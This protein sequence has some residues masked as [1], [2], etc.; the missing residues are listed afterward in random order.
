MTNAKQNRNGFS[1]LEIIA[2][3]VISAALAAFGI[4]FLRPAGDSGKQRSCDL[5][6]ELLQN[7]VQRYFDNTGTMPRAD[8]AELVDPQYSGSVLPSCPVTRE[9]YMLDRAGTV[10]CPTHEQTRGQ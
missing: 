10:A 6:R 7:D 1:L 9:A 3:V 4:Q 8:L 5:T 2:A